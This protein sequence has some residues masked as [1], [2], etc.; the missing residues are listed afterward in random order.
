VGAL[1]AAGDQEVRNDVN[2]KDT[3]GGMKK[4]LSRLGRGFGVLAGVGVLVS[5]M[6]A[7]ADV[8]HCEVTGCGS[9]TPVLLGTPI[10]GLSLRG[11]KRNGVSLDPRLR[12]DPRSAHRSAD[13]PSGAVLGVEGGRLVGKYGRNKCSGHALLGM[14]FDIVVEANT[15]QPLL[16]PL[17]RVEVN[18]QQQ[19]R[20]VKAK[21]TVR[22]DEKSQVSTWEL[23]R[24]TAIPTYR[25]VWHDVSDR[26][27]GQPGEREIRSVEPVALRR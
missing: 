4:N 6:D 19:R 23:P 24:A 21:V 10:E 15:L 9:N 18:T 27:F 20:R 25:L 3:T 17:S 14:T 13:C 11:T 16:Q 22:I 1:A 26:D 7:Q 12:R 5:R 8:P 2:R